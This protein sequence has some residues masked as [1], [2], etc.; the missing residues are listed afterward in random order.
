MYEP[1]ELVAVGFALPLLSVVAVI[2][3]FLA[4]RAGKDTRVAIDDWF[5]LIALLFVVAMGV[6]QLYGSVGGTPDCS[7]ELT[8][9]RHFRWRTWTS[10]HT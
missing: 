2:L 6:A 7:K 1:S 3:R 10:N 4:R 9:S 8:C 5:I